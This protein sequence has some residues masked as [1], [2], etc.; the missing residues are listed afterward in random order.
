MNRSGSRE[1]MINPALRLFWHSLTASRLHHAVRW[2]HGVDCVSSWLSAC[3]ML[4]LLGDLVWS[5][6]I[7]GV[8]VAQRLK[9]MSGTAISNLVSGYME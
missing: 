1:L 7:S 2:L 9:L 3:G 8:I 4:L 6:Q 5:D